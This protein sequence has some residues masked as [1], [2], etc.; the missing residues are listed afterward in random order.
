MELNLTDEELKQPVTSALAGNA[1]ANRFQAIGDASGSSMQ[2]PVSTSS[3][4]PTRNAGEAGALQ[5]NLQ[6]QTLNL[7]AD[8]DNN[9]IFNAGG[10][11]DDFGSGMGCLPSEERLNQERAELIEVYLK[12]KQGI[13]TFE[14]VSTNHFSSLSLRGLTD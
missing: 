7:N 8:D 4:E 3:P 12:M 11:S 9:S 13:Q 6:P 10:A 1:A 5:A 2:P 14:S